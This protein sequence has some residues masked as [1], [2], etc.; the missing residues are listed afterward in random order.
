M[1]KENTLFSEIKSRI[2]GA[3]QRV[4]TGSFLIGTF[5]G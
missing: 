5:G 3:V 4:L 1:P 2:T